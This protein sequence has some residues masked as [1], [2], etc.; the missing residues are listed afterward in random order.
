MV[1]CHI[2]TRS[3]TW[4][5]HGDIAELASLQLQAREETIAVTSAIIMRLYFVNTEVFNRELCGS[6]DPKMVIKHLRAGGF[7]VEPKSGQ[8]H[9]RRNGSVRE[10]YYAIRGN[11]IGDYSAANDRAE[12]E[13]SI[14]PLARDYQV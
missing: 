2:V 7:L 9:R 4:P 13:P 8:A 6:L 1:L 10:H 12:P 5:G 11:V 3:T 14:S